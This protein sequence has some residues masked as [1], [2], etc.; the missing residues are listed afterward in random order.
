LASTAFALLVAGGLAGCVPTP[1]TVEGRD[2]AR[3][4]DGFV[5]V[6][7]IV[8][9]VV[10][11]LTTFAIVRYRREHTGPPPPQV[12]GN[13]LVEGIWTAIP[14]AIVIAL[15]AFTLVVLGSVEGR[16]ER[17]AADIRVEGFRWGWTFSYPSERV[18][19]SGIG[20]PGPEAVV[21]VG[22]P[23]RVT[24]VGNDVIHSFFVPQFLFKRDLVPGRENTFEFTIDAAGTYRGQCAEFCGVLHSQMPFTLRAVPP[25]EY[26]AWLASMRTAP[27]AGGAQPAAPAAS[28]PTAGGS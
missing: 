26:A 5:V 21:P 11:G 4:Y 16:S 22:E 3:L 27:R 14:V 25:A 20:Q 2:I 6:A 17:P 9:L 19:V 10:F 12:H 1:V 8:G 23:I 7:I 24:L 13:L 15:F 18:A 28:T